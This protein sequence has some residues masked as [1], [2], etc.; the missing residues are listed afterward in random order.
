MIKCISIDTSIMSMKLEK[1][2]TNRD[3]GCKHH[4]CRICSAEGEFRSYLVREMFYGTREEFEYFSCPG[5]NC[6]QIA[7]IPENIGKYYS[8]GYYSFAVPQSV[9]NFPKTITDK[10]PLNP[11]FL[12]SRVTYDC[13]CI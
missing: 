10:N 4:K 5:C 1:D 8:E 7:C 11:I 9:E 12:E 3:L 13:I 2:I 6:L